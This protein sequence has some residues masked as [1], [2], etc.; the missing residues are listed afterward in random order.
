[1]NDLL[2]KNE[3]H[4]IQKILVRSVNWI[5]D[6]VMATP[7]LGRI[8]TAFPEAEI[9]V[10][11]NPLVAELFSYHP[12]CDR[13]IV[14]D[15][16]D[17]HRGIRGFLRFC[18]GLWREHFDLAILL[19]NAIEAAFMAAFAMIPHRAGYKTDGRGWLLN[20]GV[21]TRESKHGLHH[22]EYY[23]KMVEDLGLTGE[24]Q[25]LKLALADHEKQ[26]ASEQLPGSGWLAINP[27]AAYGSAKRWIPERFAAVADQLAESHGLQVVLTGGP[28]EQEIGFDIEKNMRCRPL[29]LIGTT[30]VRQL[31][32]VLDR[33]HLMVTN[34]SG[35]MHIAAALG[36]PIVAVFG[37]TDHKTTS[38]LSENHRIVR[39]DVYC[40]PCMLRQC[41]IDHRCMEGVRVEH[42]LAAAEQLLGADQ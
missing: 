37:P 26:W 21:P 4:K 8:R 18:Y 40:S 32:A 24:A 34:D 17:R 27:G 15:K 36:V 25:G 5:G 12:Y 33:C 38:P 7:A 35:P 41:P 39:H 31:M 2:K 11:A 1:M 13:V 20:Y 14:F 22:T 16:K 3:S 10:I 23:L 29:N 9:V 30:N 19:Q 6:A 28:A 42:V